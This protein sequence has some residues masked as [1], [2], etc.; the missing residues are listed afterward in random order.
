MRKTFFFALLLLLSKASFA[1]IDSLVQP[2]VRFSP[3]MIANLL[4]EEKGYVKLTYGQPFKKGRKIFGNLVPFS[5]LWRLGANEATEITVSKD[6]EVGSKK[7]KAGTYTLFATPNETKWTIYFN[8]KLGQWGTFE[9]QE[10]DNVL[11]T[12]IEVQ[13][14]TDVYEGFTIEL[15]ELSSNEITVYF[16]WD[17]VKA[18]MPIKL[19]ENIT[20]TPLI[21][22]TAKQRRKRLRRERREK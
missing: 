13:Q 19:I 20:A 12:E 6:F 5:G 11:V 3:T 4:S 22:E 10:L 9:Y 21:K 2:Q 7:M 15:R 1:K 14:N 16:L 8:K 17:D 18:V